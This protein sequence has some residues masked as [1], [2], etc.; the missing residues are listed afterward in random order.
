MYVR[1]YKAAAAV[2][3]LLLDTACTRV[4]IEDHS[5]QFNE[6]AGSV[7]NRL[8]LL[9]AVR[10]SK[11]YPLQLTKIASYTGAGGWN[12]GLSP[13]LF[14]ATGA[15]AGPMTDW[16]PSL[17]LKSGV[18]QLALA[19]LNTEEAQQKLKTQ[20]SF[21]AFSLYYATAGNWDKS[22]LLTLFLDSVA[23]VSTLHTAMDWTALATCERVYKEKKEKEKVEHERV[24]RWASQPIHVQVKDASVYTVCNSWLALE[25]M[26]KGSWGRFGYLVDDALSPKKALPL[27]SDPALREAAARVVREFRDG[28][29]CE[30]EPF[31]KMPNGGTPLV[32]TY[33]SSATSRCAYLAMRVLGMKLLLLDFTV[34]KVAQDRS[35]GA[36]RTE[37]SLKPGQ[38]KVVI[39]VQV[40]SKA[41][42][43][44]TKKVSGLFKP[45]FANPVLRRASGS[46]FEIWSPENSVSNEVTVCKEEPDPKNPEKKIPKCTHGGIEVHGMEFSFRSPENLIRYLGS[47]IALEH[48]SRPPFV[49]KVW[50]PDCLLARDRRGE[51]GAAIPELVSGGVPVFTIRRGLPAAGGSAVMIQD[52]DGEMFYI[53]RSEAR[54]NCRDMTMQ[55]FAIVQD[56]LNS[57]VSKQAL[58]QSTSFVLAPSQ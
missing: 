38:N 15:H 32:Y 11:D 3:V 50:T 2:I 41:A 22:L 1:S 4:E 53:P 8:L 10:A 30:G 9:N 49:A 58:P 46:T 28:D 13:Q 17:S 54:G 44:G 55:T 31:R 37:D 48:Y 27:P 20:L 26:Y 24:R 42:E 57:A 51:L 14:N 16:R 36:A 39:D 19:D 52:P 40:N 25:Y 56:V 35:D 21:D 5:Y 12:A 34:F 6:A 23:I 29:R 7:E 33:E 18:S 45:F 47:L 43:T